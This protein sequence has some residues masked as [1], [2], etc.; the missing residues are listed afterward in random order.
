[1]YFRLLAC[2]SIFRPQNIRFR[3]ELE[4]IRIRRFNA[5]ASTVTPSIVCVNVTPTENMT[6]VEKTFCIRQNPTKFHNTTSQVF[7]SRFPYLSIRYLTTVRLYLT[8]LVVSVIHPMIFT[9]YTL[10]IYLSLFTLT[11]I[12]HPPLAL[13]VTLKWG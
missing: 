1:M 2:H 12:L 4:L 9:P 7:R 11:F 5:S 6:A 3:L 8:S 10:T 13:S